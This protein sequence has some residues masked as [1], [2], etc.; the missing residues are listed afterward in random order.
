MLGTGSVL[1][2]PPATM[3]Q[4]E[5]PGN[6]PLTYYVFQFHSKKGIDMDRCIKAGGDLLINIDTL[7]YTEKDGKGTRKYFDRATASC[8]RFEM[9]T[10]TLNNPGPSHI[11]HQHIETEVILVI[12]GEMGMTIDGNSFKGNAGDFFIAESGK[13]HGV[14]NEGTKPCSYF[15]F[16]WK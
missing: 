11:P 5:N 1:L 9:H 4:F 13:M 2:I 12:D 6:I 3:Q 7:P 8:E 16:K 15:A 10:T 14:R